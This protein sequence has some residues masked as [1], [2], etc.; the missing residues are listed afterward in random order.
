MQL[1]QELLTLEDDISAVAVLND[2]SSALGTAAEVAGSAGSE[3]LLLRKRRSSD[4]LHMKLAYL[5]DDA[6]EKGSFPSLV[7]CTML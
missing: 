6:P 1:Q 2:G 7:S 5:P 3:E 4:G